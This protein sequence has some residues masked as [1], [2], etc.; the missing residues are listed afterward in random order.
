MEIEF[1]SFHVQVSL[2]FKGESLMFPGNA[3]QHSEKQRC[4]NFLYGNIL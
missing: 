3:P 2:F 1:Q 4:E